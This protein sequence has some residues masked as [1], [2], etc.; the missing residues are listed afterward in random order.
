MKCPP[1]TPSLALL[2]ARAALAII[3]ALAATAI[4]SPLRAQSIPDSPRPD[5]GARQIPH[6]ADDAERRASAS[7]LPSALDTRG[8]WPASELPGVPDAGR[9]DSARLRHRSIS[10]TRITSDEPRIDGSLAD[11]IWSRA[12]TDPRFRVDDFVESNPQPGVVPALPTVAAFAFDDEAVYVAVRAYDPAPDSIVAPYPRRDFEVRS[13]WI[14]VE[15]DT[16]HDRRTGVSLGV[17]P[18]GVQVDGT[19][20]NDV[21]YDYSWNAVWQAATTIDSLGWTAEFR[22]PFTQ[23]RAAAPE[24]GARDVVWGMNIYRHTVHRGASS[25]WSPRLP[26]FGGRVVSHFNDLRGIELP[27]EQH[28]FELHPFVLGE[29]KPSAR[30]APVTLAPPGSAGSTKGSGAPAIRDRRTSDVSAGLDAT[31]HLM[32]GV[33]LEATVNPDFGQVEADP[34]QINLTTFETFLQEKRP[35]FVNG[36]DVIHFDL[37]VPFTTRDD[38]F[39]LEQA[40]YSRRIGAPPHG[41][42]PAS[43]LAANTPLATDVLGALELSGRLA[44]HWTVG[45]M[46][47]ATRDASARYVDAGGNVAR[48]R[49]EPRSLFGAARLQRDFHDGAS[50]AGLFASGMDRGAMNDDLAFLLPKRALFA[51]ADGRHRIGNYEVSGFAG[52]SRVTGDAAAITGVMHGPGHFLQRPGASYAHFDSSAT[53]ATGVAARVRFARVDGGNLTWSITGYGISP[54]FDV[55]DQGFQRNADWLLA[56]GTVRYQRNEPHDGKHIFRRWAIG[57]DQLGVGWSWGGERRA[58]VLDFHADGDLWSNWGGSLSVNQELSGLSLEVLRGGAAVKMPARTAFSVG[59]Y[60]DTRRAAH[61]QLNTSYAREPGSGSSSLDIA[62]TITARVVDRLALT[63]SVEYTRSV[64]GWQ[65][66]GRPVLD[67]GSAQIVLARLRASTLS[68]TARADYAFSPHLTLPLYAQPYFGAGRYDRPAHALQRGTR[69]GIEELGA[70]AWRL[71]DGSLA[72]DFSD[73]E[74][75]DSSRT[76]LIP[77]PDF[78]LRELHGSAVLRWE[79]RPGSELFLVWTQTRSGSDHIGSLDTGRDMSDLFALHPKNVLLMKISYHWE[80]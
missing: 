76:A 27:R 68:F 64:N 69:A 16:R 54:R 12:F 56:L 44:N 60:S 71:D 74:S 5:S 36:A 17:N 70:R 10:A 65:Y 19:W 57:S 50:A 24:R 49:V 58:T 29:S 21:D 22:I 33:T 23:L 8:G 45:A 31:V 4:D 11:P 78:T 34:S 3:V 13:D 43:A 30:V 62:P 6:P 20:D 72:I 38:D 41:A 75:R 53:S 61:L 9:V 48:M 77:D 1:T 15:L 59:I 55:S 66:L 73:D 42:P 51:G 18:R 26:S 52:T 39:T 35:F 28:R 46:A 14:F 79:Y 40:F 67:D 37:G 25:N 63:G 2:I 80:P 32:H 7:G 47:A